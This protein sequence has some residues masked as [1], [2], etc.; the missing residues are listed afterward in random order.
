[1][2]DREQPSPSPSPTDPSPNGEEPSGDSSTA[3]PPADSAFVGDPGPAFDPEA[4]APEAPEPRP[5]AELHALPGLEGWEQDAVESLLR[6]QG[7]VLHAVAGVGDQDWLYT[8]DDLAAIAPPLTRI[9][10]RYPAT[11][12]AAGSGDELALM[13][14]LGAY[15]T[16]S[17]AERRDVLEQLREEE[18]VPITGDAPAP[19]SPDESTPS[20]ESPW[21]TR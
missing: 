13:L 8:E 4:P 20:D 10:N 3:S 19:G 18:P 6:G 2:R 14:G 17:W 7:A 5:D 21:K 9:L 11:R 15:A 12:A 16:R 1:M